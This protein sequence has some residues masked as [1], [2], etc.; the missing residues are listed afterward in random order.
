LRALAASAQPFWPIGSVRGFERREGWPDDA[1]IDDLLKRTASQY[2][3]GSIRVERD[4]AWFRW[5]YAPGQEYSYSAVL[6]VHASGETGF[7]VYS[8]RDGAPASIV[9]LIATSPD[10][11]VAA[12]SHALRD[13][14]SRRIGHVLTMTSCPHTQRALRRCGFFR[15]RS[16]P[17]IVRTMTHETLAANIHSYG[18]WVVQ[19]GDVDTL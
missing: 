15:R 18:A 11:R 6:V 12:L 9:E 8:P 14:K 16:N 4:L 10:A 17:L 7:C 19:G 2:P 5:R 13:L 3:A 1:V